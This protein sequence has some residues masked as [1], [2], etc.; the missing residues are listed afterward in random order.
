MNYRNALSN[1]IDKLHDMLSKLGFH[2]IKLNRKDF[3]FGYDSDSNSSAISLDPEGLRFFDF[4]S[5]KSGDLLDLIS[6]KLGISIGKAMNW[7]RGF[8]GVDIGFEKVEE[9]PFTRAIKEIKAN[10]D[11]EMELVEYDDSELNQYEKILSR[12]FMEDGIGLSAHIKFDIRY[13]NES[14]RVLIPI[15]NENGKLV[16][17]IGRLNVKDV[18]K[19]VAKYLPL[20]AYPK[21][22]VLY[23]LHENNDYL[24]DTMIIVESEKSVI[25]AH[26]YGYKN[27]VALGG[28]FIS[29][30]HLRLI[31]QRRPKR[32]ILMLDKGLNSEHIKEQRD[33]LFSSNPFYKVNVG[34]IDSNNIEELPN[35]ANAFDLDIGECEKVIGMVKWLG[36]NKED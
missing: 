32:V 11:D 8:L 30:H 13:D 15:R 33:R 31:R 5:S 1:D 7:L 25:K 17:I 4:K 21:S 6:Y 20:I 12:L 28:N 10:I 14:D 19:G 24:G 16:G 23:G 22:K 18:K 29:N 36:Y 9:N 26:M 34:Y 35:K 2:N 27:V 3:R